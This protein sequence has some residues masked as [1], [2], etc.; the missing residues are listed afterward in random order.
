LDVIRDGR[1]LTHTL[2]TLTAIAWALVLGGGCGLVLGY[3]IAKIPVLED[4]V[5]P[6]VVGFQA[7]PIVAYAPL[8]VIWFGSGIESKVVTGSLIVF[9]PMLMNTIVGIRSVP[10]GLRELMKVSRASGWQTFTKLE[11]P[12]AMPIL[13]GGLKMSATLAVIGTVVGEFVAS[14]AGLGFLI[15]IA[16]SQ[17]DTPL[18]IVAVLTLTTLAL[19]LYSA[20]ALLERYVLAW[21]RR[22]R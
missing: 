1:L 9:F 7:T 22:S 2:V 4:V 16:R 3:L 21:Q 14:R 10:S 12:A 20:V 6:V 17:F 13:I 8:L 15:S 11:I 5:S 18:V 19:A